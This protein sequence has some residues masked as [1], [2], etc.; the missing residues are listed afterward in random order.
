MRNWDDGNAIDGCPLPVELCSF[1]LCREAKLME[2]VRAS[3]VDGPNERRYS[4]EGRISGERLLEKGF[5]MGGWHGV[6]LIPQER[7]MLSTARGPKGP[8]AAGQRGINSCSNYSNALFLRY[9]SV[10]SLELA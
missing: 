10:W 8:A 7:G 2:Q 4:V 5:E 1:K 6:V 9:G 3:G